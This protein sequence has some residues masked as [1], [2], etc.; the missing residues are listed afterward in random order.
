VNAL[1]ALNQDAWHGHGTGTQSILRNSGPS[2]INF[3][4]FKGKCVYRKDRIPVPWLLHADL[5]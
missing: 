2:G 3:Y 1:N 4:N 5:K